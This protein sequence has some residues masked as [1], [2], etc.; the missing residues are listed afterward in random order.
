MLGK[1]A[2]SRHFTHLEGEVVIVSSLERGKVS[3]NDDYDWALFIDRIA[4][5]QL[6]IQ[7]TWQTGDGKQYFVNKVV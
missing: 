2:R 6:N 1:T 3:A 4:K 7:V 5:D